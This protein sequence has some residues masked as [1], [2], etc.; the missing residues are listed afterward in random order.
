MENEGLSKSLRL[1]NEAVILIHPVVPNL[2]ALLSQLSEDT[3]WFTALDL[4]DTFFAYPYILTLNF[5]LHLNT[6]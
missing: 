6:P 5:S 2:Y 1:I 4:K 3:E